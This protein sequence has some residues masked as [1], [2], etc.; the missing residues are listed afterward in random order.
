[1]P[2]AQAIRWAVEVASKVFNCADVVTCGT[3]SVIT[4]LEFL[5]HHFS[6]TGHKALLRTRQFILS[7]WQSPFRSPHAKRLPQGGYVLT[8]KSVK[9]RREDFTGLLTL[10]ANLCPFSWRPN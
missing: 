5:Q 8:A 1:M 6:Q 4:T 3:L 9:F 7:A 10:P 2:L